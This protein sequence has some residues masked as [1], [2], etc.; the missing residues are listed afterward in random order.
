MNSLTQTT[1]YVYLLHFEQQIAPGRHTCQ[2]Y[3]GYADN[4]PTR[5]QEH[6]TGRGARLTQVARERG[7]GW[8][9]A[10]V[11]P[12]NRTL[13]RRLKNRKDAPHLCPLCGQ[14]SPVHYADEIPAGDIPDL[15]L[16]F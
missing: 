1:G 15:L 9:V 4:L 8:R 3:I 14:P 10:R 16:P 11:W 6:A 2:H 12:G 13:E 5:L 7:I